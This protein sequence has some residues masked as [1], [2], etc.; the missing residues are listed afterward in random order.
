MNFVDPILFQCRLN[1]PALAIGAPGEALDLV[2]YGRLERFI[3]NVSRVAHRV[4][5]ERGQTVA[6]RIADN[7]LHAAIILGLARLGVVTASAYGRM[8][9][10]LRVDAV[11]ADEGSGQNGR[12]VIRADSTWI[13]GD[14]LPIEDSRLYQ[15]GGSDRCRVILTS[16]TTGEPKAIGL[17]HDQVAARTSRLQFACGNRFQFCSRLFCDLGLPSSPAFRYMISM[18]SRGG[19]IF[20][21]GDPQATMQAFDLYKVQSFAAAPSGLAEY[22][23]VFEAYDAFQC[24][25]DHIITTGGMMPKG[26]ADRVRSRMCSNLFASYGATETGP[27]AVAPAQAIASVPGAVGF[28]LPDCTVEIVDDKG[29][30][31]PP[32]ENG[33]VRVRGPHNAQE[34]LGD[35]VESARTFR[36][37]YFH[38]GD[39]GYLSPDRLLVISGREK[40][41][42]NIGG[43][44][45]SPERIEAVIASFTGIDQAAVF[46]E[47]DEM[48]VDQIC[49]VLVSHAGFDEQRLRAH[50]EQRLGADFVP[51]RFVKST[52]LPQNEQGK[53]VRTKLPE[54]AGSRST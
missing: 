32:G 29:H 54:I 26:L 4:G 45:I 40:S 11:I 34:Y 2:S 28:V 19:T 5:L 43:N 44:K 10:E 17:T 9:E 38:P 1:A 51:A 13:E 21:S 46:S 20:F 15:G 27:V 3:H 53:L 39:I 48:G 31:L 7:V 25:F 36:D 50:C 14:G 18:L 33:L 8:P 49:A 41:V 52:G 6:I 16:G 35:P 23:K 47:Q 12:S 37:G 24:S 42:L 22:L 30:P